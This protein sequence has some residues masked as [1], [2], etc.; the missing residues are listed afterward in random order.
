MSVGPYDKEPN[1]N[2]GSCQKLVSSFLPS[3]IVLN[4]ISCVIKVIV[5]DLFPKE[6]HNPVSLSEEDDNEKPLFYWW[7][8]TEEFNENGELKLNLSRL[9][10]LTP[11]LKVLREMERSTLIAPEGLDEPRQKL[12]T[13]HSGGFYLPTGGISKEEMDILPVITILLV[14]FFG[15]G[16]KLDHKLN[17]WFSGLLGVPEINAKWV[18][19]L[20]FTEF[21]LQSNGRKP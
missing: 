13:Y 11:R 16:K 19:P 9:S 10:S 14:G 18:L 1:K 2:K 15:S 8:S 5:G 12:F 21:G 3:A 17:R 4:A 20:R 6:V 7:R